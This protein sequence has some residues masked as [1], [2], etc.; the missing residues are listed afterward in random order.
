MRRAL[1][2]RIETNLSSLLEKTE[3][4]LKKN[5][6]KVLALAHALEVYKTISGEDVVAV[7]TGGRGPLVDGTPYQNRSNLKKLEE[8]HRAAVRAHFEHKKPDIP[9]PLFSNLG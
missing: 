5:R 3:D 1:A 6:E 9:L 8:Y 7:M 2:D 4:I